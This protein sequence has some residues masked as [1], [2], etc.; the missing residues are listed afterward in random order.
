MKKSPCSTLLNRQRIAPNQ[1][2]YQMLPSFTHSGSFHNMQ[3]TAVVQGGFLAASQID[4]A[5]QAIHESQTDPLHN[6]T[7]LESKI[8]YLLPAR[9]GVLLCKVILRRVGG[10]VGFVEVFAYQQ[11][12]LL[13]TCS[14]TII[15]E[16]NKAFTNVN[17]TPLTSILQLPY[18][19]ATS[20][21]A[22]T[23][24]SLSQMQK[25]K[26]T[27]EISK[28]E[29]NLATFFNSHHHAFD[30]MSGT[31]WSEMNISKQAMN[32]NGY[33]QAGFVSA[34]LDNCM[35]TAFMGFRR[36]KVMYAPTLELQTHYFHRV[37][38]GRAEFVTRIIHMDNQFGYL[39][40]E[41][42]QNGILMAKGESTL[43][44]TY[45]KM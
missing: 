36:W 35:A 19:R 37:K 6:V 17:Q 12:K 5:I 29:S 21:E 7:L 14:A 18:P 15:L 30:L 33:V 45:P 40:V 23:L 38:K 31:L 1:Y 42:F 25:P 9:I 27:I 16:R 3:A 13:V 4:A 8:T 20:Q 41:L 43:L 32:E 34:M 22:T 11:E 2:T 10:R 24:L 28:Q 26:T 39:E 44:M